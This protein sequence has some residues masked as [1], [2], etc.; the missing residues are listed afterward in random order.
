MSADKKIQLFK[1]FFAILIFW[2]LLSVLFTEGAGFQRNLYFGLRNNAEVRKLQDLLRDLNFFTG[3]STGN[4][5]TLTHEAV[6]RFQ[7]AYAIPTTGFFGPISRRNANSILSTKNNSAE[8]SISNTVTAPTQFGGC[9]QL[10]ADHNNL[11]ERRINLVVVGINYESLEH[12]KEIARLHIDWDKQGIGIFS[13][14]P[15]KSNRDLFNIM[16]VNRVGNFPITQTTFNLELEQRTHGELG[17]TF[18]TLGND[19]PFENTRVIGFLNRGSSSVLTSYAYLNELA[20]N[21][22]PYPVRQ[23]FMREL[24]LL[25]LHESGA[26][27]IAG[28]YDEYGWQNWLPEPQAM[29]NANVPWLQQC[30]YVDTHADTSCRAENGENICVLPSQSVVDRCN[31]EAPWH[32]L[33]G[34]GCGQDGVI[35]CDETNSRNGLEVKCSWN[36]GCSPNDFAPSSRTVLAHPGAEN[37]LGL[38]PYHERLICQKIKETIDTIGGICGSLCINGCIDGQYCDQGICRQRI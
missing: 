33:V 14:E 8:T 17:N 36:A 7:A 37:L 26:H 3:P 15:Y 11:S 34:D 29:R 21:L 6:R 22:H 16:L 19:C 38:S 28:L 2:G 25:A 13:F 35:D 12:V 4:F 1:I 30:F 5:F 23:D 10:D 27:A 32:D 9:L 18:R 24:S 20:V 31:R